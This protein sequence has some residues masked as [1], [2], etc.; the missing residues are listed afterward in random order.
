MLSPDL[1]THLNPYPEI[2]I[3]REIARSR[4]QNMH[5]KDKET[6]DRQHRTPHFEVNELVLV[7]IYRHPDTDQ[8]AEIPQQKKKVER[9]RHK[10]DRMNKDEKEAREQEIAELTNNDH[11]P[12]TPPRHLGNI[13][14][15]LATILERL[16]PL[17]PRDLDIAAFDG[18]KFTI[19]SDH[20]ALQWLKSIKNPTGRLFR[21][22]LRISAY[23]YEIRYIKG[24]QQYEA[25]L[26]SR[27]PFCG[28]LDADT[29]KKHQN[30]TPTHPHITQDTNGLHTITRK[31]VTKIL[32]PEKLRSTLLNKVH[33]EYNHPG[34]SQMSRLI[35][36][37]YNWSGMSRD[38]KNH[39]NSCTTCQLTKHP[40]GPTYAWAFPSK[41]TSTLTYI[42]AIKKVS[43]YGSPKR[44][45]SDR[46]PSF[47][48][49]KFR[50]FLIAHGIQPLNTTSN[51]PQANGLCERLNSTIAGKL[52]LLHLENPKTSWTK[53]VNKVTQVY[54]NTPHS[55]TGFPPSYLLFGIIPTE[56]SNHI[57]PYP[58]ID[59]ARQQAYQRTQL[60]HDKDKQKFDL[61]HKTPNFEIGYLVLVKVYHHP[62]T[63]K[64]TPYFTGPYTI[65]EI[66]SPNVVKINRPNQPLNKEHDTIHVLRLF[67]GHDNNNTIHVNKLRP[68]TESIPHIAPPTMQAHYVQ[69]K[70][71]DLFPFQHLSPDLFQEYQLP[72]IPSSSQPRLPLIPNLFTLIQ[73]EPT[74]SNNASPVPQL[75]INREP[76]WSHLKSSTLQ[77]KWLSP[78]LIS[79]I[80]NIGYNM[81]TFFIFFILF[82]DNYFP[83]ITD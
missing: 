63:G 22:S 37:Q 80:K 50:R 7:K 44:L 36:S 79:L 29:I 56:F 73:V 2:T 18:T 62:N 33:L 1:Q 31:G 5:K 39:V 16:Q 57:N 75:Q 24:T 82:P 65:L 35:S 12:T 64:L 72:I 69:P 13:I 47:T 6:F 59:I 49:E 74:S 76:T 68:Y 52:R 54:N 48:S 53:L 17:H 78:Q 66:I 61:N 34:I 27:N 20:H 40:K 45:L 11:G 58:P 32:I 10:V 25:D 28:F 67:F 83:Y 23:D 42:K 46:A 21:W 38:I 41:S 8:T 81:K 4:T 26:L 9:I 3:A 19:F 51:N 55:V 70:D 30:N 60:K 14:L 71:N 15:Q 77:H 43:V